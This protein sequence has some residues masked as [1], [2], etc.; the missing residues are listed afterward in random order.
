MLLNRI[1][2]AAFS[3]FELFV[4]RS[5]PVD[6]LQLSSFSYFVVQIL[7]QNSVLSETVQDLPQNRA[8]F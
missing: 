8:G 7:V 5:K 3:L 2:L 1:L 6:G 4:L